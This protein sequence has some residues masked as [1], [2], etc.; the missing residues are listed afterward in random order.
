MLEIMQ[1][2]K[3]ICNFDLVCWPIT[4][5]ENFRL[6]PLIRFPSVRYCVSGH[7][8]AHKD[9]GRV[10][11]NSKKASEWIKLKQWLVEYLRNSSQYIGYYNWAT[12]CIFILLNVLQHEFFF[13]LI[14]K[15]CSKNIDKSVST[16]CSAVPTNCYAIP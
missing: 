4:F 6:L 7:S 1:K 5:A 11:V 9:A 8:K 16:K 13:S 3:Q 12:L 14:D 10:P 2:I 15:F